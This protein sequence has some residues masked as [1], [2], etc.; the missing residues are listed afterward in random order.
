MSLQNRVDPWARLCAVTAKG[1][2]MG[3]RGILHDENRQIVSQWEHTR[4]VT[5]KVEFQGIQRRPFSPRNYS[6]LFFL[7]EATAFAA[8]HRPCA[9]CRKD[10]FKEFK[11]AWLA[12]NPELRSTPR[13]SIEEVNKIIHTER[14][15]KG[16]N[17]ISFEAPVKDL[18]Q[19]TLIDVDGV[20]LLVWR[21]ALLP[22]SFEGYGPVRDDLPFSTMV[23]VLTPKSVIRVFAQ[24]FRPD[25]HP[26]AN[27]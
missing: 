27:A 5:C 6:E 21:D 23:R 26:S 9:Y 1:A 22:W 19:G 4:W 3:N 13:P 2:L 8:G 25:V 12:S 18:P 10:R 14:A 20:A 15:A 17:K 11:T 24:G 16:G 7:D